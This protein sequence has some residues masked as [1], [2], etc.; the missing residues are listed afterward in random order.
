[1]FIKNNKKGFTLIELLAVIII[2]GILLTIALVATKSYIIKVKRTSFYTSV[3][4]IIDTIKPENI[5]EEK[6]FCMYS[7]VK[8]KS[9]ETELIDDMYIIVHKKYDKLIYSVLAQNRDEHF[10]IDI[11]D[12]SNTKSDDVDTW[13]SNEFEQTYDYQLGVLADLQAKGEATE[14]KVCGVKK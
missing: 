3:S 7:Y 2:L 1:M 11:Y 6:D 10:I 12:F 8:N 5:I 14:Y 4:N 9:D 13:L